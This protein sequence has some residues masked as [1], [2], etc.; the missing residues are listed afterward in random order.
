M[1]D[2]REITEK[3]EEVKRKIMVMEWDK[4]RNQ[5]NA[6]RL[7]IFN[8]LKEER[9]KLEVELKSFSKDEEKA[10]IDPDK[11]LGG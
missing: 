7:P 3:L 11:T 10:A 4:S 2:E 6:G 5:L 8:S 9:A 1:P